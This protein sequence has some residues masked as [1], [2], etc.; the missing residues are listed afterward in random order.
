MGLCQISRIIRA[1]GQFLLASFSPWVSTLLRR[2][3]LRFRLPCCLLPFRLLGRRIH[4]LPCPVQELYDLRE[5]E[6]Y[7]SESQVLF[8][9]EAARENKITKQ[10]Y[11]T[12]DSAKHELTGNS[13][14]R[15]F[16]IVSFHP[17]GKIRKDRPDWGRFLASCRLVYLKCISS[18]ALDKI[19]PGT[20]LAMLKDDGTL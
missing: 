7:A 8:L 6:H 14:E 10:E 2:I 17:E 16:Y 11:V 20:R 12:S 1:T 18:T 13:A 15:H 4:I 9:L 19:D 3:W 5:V